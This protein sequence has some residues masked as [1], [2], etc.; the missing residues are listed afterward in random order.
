MKWTDKLL[1]WIARKA[2][3]ATLKRSEAYA[4]AKTSRMTGNWLAASD[5]VNNIISSS[6]A[7][8]RNRIRQLVRD[9]PYFARAVNAAVD[10]TVGPGLV[11][12]ARIRTGQDIQL[13]Q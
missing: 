10:Y 12:Q 3:A 13:D 9:F 7:T 2:V 6:S 8:V 11:Y 1:R 4:A 5:T